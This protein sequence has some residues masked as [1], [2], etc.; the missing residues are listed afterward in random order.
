MHVYSA[1][2]LA[3]AAGLIALSPVFAERDSGLDPHPLEAMPMARWLRMRDADRADVVESY[4][5]R[6]PR[7]AITTPHS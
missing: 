6:R 3:Y 1:F 7:M 4:A 5:Q 2:W